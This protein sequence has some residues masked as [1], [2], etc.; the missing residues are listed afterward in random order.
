MNYINIRDHRQWLPDVVRQDS[1]RLQLMMKYIT[2]ESLVVDD[3]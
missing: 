1:S 2:K 3:E